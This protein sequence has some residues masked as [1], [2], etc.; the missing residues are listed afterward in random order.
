[1]NDL[2]SA[3]DA[4]P[5]GEALFD[6]DGTLIHHDIAEAVLKR[7]IARG[8]LPLGAARHVGTDDPWAAY[9]ALDP[10]TQCVAA[11]AALGGL[12]RAEIAELV[13]DAFASG[14]IAPNAPIVALAQAVARRH[15]VWILTG[16]PEVLG[17]F[18]G[19][20]LGIPHVR[21]VRLAREGDRY[22]DRVEGIVSCAEGK[23]KANWVYFGRRPVFA[24]GDSPWDLHLLRI[25]HVARTTGRIGGMEYPAFP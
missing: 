12:R 5:P 8:P 4:L 22:T 24:I 25:A 18:A 3:L 10:V 9:L 7:L 19:E 16:S 21:G 20:R 14:D 11:A 23:V 2:I 15:R 17:E 6:L 13:D 1:M